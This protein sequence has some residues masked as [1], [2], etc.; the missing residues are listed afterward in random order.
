MFLVKYTKNYKGL[1]TVD[2]CN[3]FRPIIH[4]T[5]KRKKFESDHKFQMQLV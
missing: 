2:L 5:W 3:A 1:I 4:M